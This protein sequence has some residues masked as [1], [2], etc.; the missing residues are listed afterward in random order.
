MTSSYRYKIIPE[1][2]VFLQYFKGIV[3]L[4]VAVAAMTQVLKD[5][6]FNA[7]YNSVVDFRDAV[8]EFEDEEIEKF[9]GFLKKQNAIDANRRAALL[10]NTPNQVLFLSIFE[11]LTENM[12]VSYKIFSTRETSVKWVSNK[13]GFEIII[14]KEIELLRSGS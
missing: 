11:L 4:D 9:I 6:D 3:N 2:K 1:Q 13:S 14:E 12:I 8:L 10:T 5:K 7:T